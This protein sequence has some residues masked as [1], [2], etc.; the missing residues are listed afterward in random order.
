MQFN[1]LTGFTF[2]N[3]QT[4]YNEIFIF[5]NKRSNKFFVAPLIFWAYL[6]NSQSSKLPC[7][8]CLLCQDVD[9]GFN[10][11]SLLNKIL[12]ATNVMSYRSFSKFSSR[13]G[14]ITRHW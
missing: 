1:V 9:D 11:K 13:L 10:L 14:G 2:L 6:V 5:I 12:Y 7:E 4:C 8:I 3:N